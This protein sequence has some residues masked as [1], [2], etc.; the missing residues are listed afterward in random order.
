ML[1]TAPTGPTLKDVLAQKRRKRTRYKSTHMVQIGENEAGNC[2][3]PG[4]D[5]GFRGVH[6]LKI[7]RTKVYLVDTGPYEQ[8]LRRCSIEMW[9]TLMRSKTTRVRDGKIWK[10]GG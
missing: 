8:V 9:K 5:Q 7:S 4:M 3:I 1:D 10:A 2:E 6:L